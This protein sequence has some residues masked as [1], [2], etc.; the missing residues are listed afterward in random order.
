M[1]IDCNNITDY[2]GEEIGR[3]YSGIVYNNK[4]DSNK[5]IKH[6]KRTRDIENVIN[7]YDI[8]SQAGNLG[9]SPNIYGELISCKPDPEKELYNTYIIMDKIQGKE[10]GTEQQLDLYFDRII[11]KIKIL[12]EHGITYPDYNI[13]NIMV[14]KLPDSDIEDAYLIDFGACKRKNKSKITIDKDKI[15]NSL[16]LNVKPPSYKMTKS[17]AEQRESA[18]RWAASN[19]NKSKKGG[20]KRNNKKTRR[21][22]K[23]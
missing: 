20:R 19:L 23:I 8:A 13:G 11:D 2:L 5:V 17:I 15:Y 1:N 10:I 9:I 4:F 7:E 6:Y 18:A 22:R 16:L 3:G 14:G 12:K 21:T